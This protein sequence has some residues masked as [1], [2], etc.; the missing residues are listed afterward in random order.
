MSHNIGILSQDDFVV[1]KST[2][3]DSMYKSLRQI[4]LYDLEQTDMSQF[5]GLVIP[6]T[7]DQEFLYL[8]RH[9]IEE[10]LDCKKIV[11]FNGH[12]FR[13]WLPNAS[14]F[15]PK[16][17]NTFKDY[18]IRIVKDH[19]IF[20]GVSENDLIFRKGVA[21]FFAR[22]HH[23]PPEGSE[24]IITFNTGEPVTYIDKVST[25][26][27]IMV[28]SGNDLLGYAIEDNSS[29]RIAR[30]LINWMFME[31]NALHKGEKNRN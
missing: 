17:I 2:I 1:E 24:I 9:I 3:D 22:G 21:G 8:K 7:I 18:Y 11:V 5:L 15:I 20:E 13:K 28:H 10:F 25:M 27:T 14:N 29:R 16:K 31:Y 19:P 4:K 6:G 23:S 30:Q 12:L 26:G